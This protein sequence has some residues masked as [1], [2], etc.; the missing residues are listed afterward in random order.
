LLFNNHPTLVLEKITHPLLTDIMQLSYCT[1]YFLPI[2]LGALLLKNRERPAFEYSLFMILLCF[3]LS[4]IGYLLFPA[5]GP[6][7][8]LD[9]L[10]TIDLKGLFAANALQE[11]LNELEGIKRDAFPSGHTGITLVVLWLAFRFEKKYFW[12][13]LP[14]SIALLF[15]TVYCR[16]HYVIDVIAGFGLALISVV[17]GH[18][19]Y[20]KWVSTSKGGRRF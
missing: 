20:M 10:Q 11:L 2:G 6:R 19:L 14:A 3:Y 8:A 15:S 4:Y 5:L 16:Y 7:F 9:H 17:L 13:I 12:L 18:L 1:Y